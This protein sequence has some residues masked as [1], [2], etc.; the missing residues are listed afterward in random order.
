MIEVDVIIFDLG[1]S[2]IQLDN[3]KE[4]FLSNLKNIRYENGLNNISA[5]DVIN[6]LEEVDLKSIIRVLGDEK[7]ASIIAKHSQTTKHKRL[8]KHLI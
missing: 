4:V 7:E 6:K 1:L 3:L 8:Q 5:L 2:S